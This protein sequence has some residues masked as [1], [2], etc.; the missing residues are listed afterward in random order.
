MQ[1][2]HAAASPYVRKVMVLLEEAG[3]TGDVT[4]IDGSGSPTAP[5]QAVT[6]CNP[7]GKIPCLV[8]DDGP[9]LYDSRVITRYLDAKYETGLYPEAGGEL[10][11]CT[12]A[13]EA[14]AD[15]IMDAAFLCVYEARVR[16]EDKR[17]D[18]WLHGQREKILRGLDALESGWLHHLAGPLDMGVIAAASALGYLD[19]RKE[20]GG[21]GDWREG[22]PALTAWAESFMDRPSLKATAPA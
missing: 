14:H 5:N 15:G 17:S 9:P 20:M 2:Y 22:R 21:W 18:E 3:K 7:L 8:R 19:F 1:L 16:E 10:L 6:A 11:W 4:L 13:L 12:L